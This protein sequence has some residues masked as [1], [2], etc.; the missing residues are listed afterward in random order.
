MRLG[1]LYQLA[2]AEKLTDQN[3][4]PWSPPK[5]GIWATELIYIVCART[6]IVSRRAVP[7]ARGENLSA[8]A[9]FLGISV[10]HLELFFFF[11]EQKNKKV[12]R[13]YIYFDFVSCR[14]FLSQRLFGK[15][16]H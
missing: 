2:C 13:S 15:A 5:A 6:V 3:P 8:Q 9:I 11:N 12:F 4:A 7:L 16:A 10:V 1:D 14:F